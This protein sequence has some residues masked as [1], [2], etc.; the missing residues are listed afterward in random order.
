MSESIEPEVAAPPFPQIGRLIELLECRRPTA[1]GSLWGASQAF[2]LAEVAQRAQ[3]PWLVITSTDLEAESFA[4]DL[5]LFGAAPAVLPAREGRSDGKGIDPESLR[6]RLRVAQTLGGPPERRPRLVVSSIL[7]LLQPIPEASTFEGQMLHLHLHQRVDLEA[8]L[9]RLVDAGYGRQPLVERPGEFSLR[10]DILDLYPFTSE[11]PLRLELFDDEIESLRTFDPDGQR[12]TATLKN[13]NI[14]LASDAGGVEDGDGATPISR[15][16]PTAT[17]VTIEPLRVEDRAE[18]LRIRTASHGQ[19]LLRLRASLGAFAKLSIQSLPAED[20]NFDVRSVQFL[21]GDLREAPQ[22]LR[23]STDADERITVFCRTDG[24]LRRLGDVMAKAASAVE[25]RFEAK[26][27]SITR[28]FRFPAANRVALN[29]RELC[30]VAGGGVTKKQRA[31]HRTRAL[32]SFFELKPGDYVVHAVHGLARFLGLERMARG[33]GEEEHLHLQFAEEVSLYVPA[34]RIDIVQ[35]YI[36]AGNAGAGS[37]PLDKIGG[38]SFRKRKERVQKALVDLA[39]DLLE[40]QAKRE[41]ERRPA[42]DADDEMVREVVAAFPYEETEDQLEVD[43]DIARDLHGP[44]PMD[45]LLCGDV[46]FGKTELAVRAALRV[47]NGGGQVALLVP[48]TLLAEQH[49]KTFAQ[50]LAGFP[51]ETATISRNVT[52]KKAKALLARVADGE[53]DVLVGTHRLLSKDV[54]FKKLGLIIVDEEQ[55]FGVAHKE[56]FKRMRHGVDV[57]SLSATPIP[58]TLH[59]SLAGVRDISALSKPPPGRQDVETELIYI[60]DEDRIREAILRERARGGQ[61]FFLHN[62]VESIGGV[63]RWLSELVPECS[64]TV[65]HGQMGARELQQVMDAFTR[66]DVDVLVAT[67]IIENGLDIPAAGTILIDRADRLGLSELHQLR[68]RVGRAN[69]KAW[70]FLV[71]DRHR[72]VRQI[73]RDRLQALQ[74]MSHLGAGFG[75]SMKDLEIRGAGNLLGP[76]Q[77]GHIG[78]IGYDMYCRLLKS[79]VEQVGQGLDPTPVRGG[80]DPAAAAFEG[81]EL[82]IG[83]RSF[84][85]EAWIPEQDA[86]IEILRQLH[87]IDGEAAAEEARSMLRDR[88]GRIP[89]EADALLRQF[90]LSA[91]LAPLGV[92]RLAWRQDRYVLAY[93]DRVALEG[94]LAGRGVD[95]RPLREGQAHLMIPGEHA[96]A[97][98]ALDWF[99]GLFNAPRTPSTPAPRR[100]QARPRT[101]SDPPDPQPT[102]PRRRRRRPT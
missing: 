53:I 77:S 85:P 83:V 38:Q 49:G 78:A 59:M 71:I 87:H 15:I 90:L 14:C 3:G 28:G 58:R 86:R 22:R 41:L 76:E 23:E 2:V 102:R 37:P 60:Q 42:W 69:Q 98:A 29:Y 48:T 75:I 7:S 81:V 24:E 36:G 84:L 5:R 63:A 67:T 99:E 16:A 50:R 52:G 1:I 91:R 56:H 80:Q 51:I 43:E 61:I 72:P 62:A 46:G 74:E 39:S 68:G 4:E 25:E 32:Q 88:Y 100:T 18:G 55:R 11:E 57:L 40:V 44:R 12:S 31:K 64:Y 33:S 6:T 47:V 94:L 21:S 65:G 97:Q 13:A 34:C 95:F 17:V 19:A 89:E 96:T 92:T 82:E 30:G 70:C 93:R 73:A 8:L 54:T 10:G 101:I 66:G 26:L 45:R 9:E 20:L 79:T 27:G 35:R